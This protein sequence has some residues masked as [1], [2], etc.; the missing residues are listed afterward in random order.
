MKDALLNLYEELR[1]WFKPVG[2][3]STEKRAVRLLVVFWIAVLV[4][5][6]FFQESAP[7]PGYDP[8]DYAHFIDLR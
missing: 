3:Q 7:T 2:P 4:Y 8:G 6:I 5:G 1:N